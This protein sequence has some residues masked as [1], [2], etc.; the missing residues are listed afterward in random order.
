MVEEE[1]VMNDG[2]SAKDLVNDKEIQEQFAGYYFDGKLSRA[3]VKHI[4]KIMIN[5]K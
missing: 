4:E 2:I 3:E 5:D 1:Y